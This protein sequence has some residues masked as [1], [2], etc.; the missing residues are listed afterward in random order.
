ME[1]DINNLK[2]LHSLEN[3]LLEIARIYMRQPDKGYLNF[4]KI[5][6]CSG[7]L[8]DKEKG[9]FNNLLAQETRNDGRGGRDNWQISKAR[10][11]MLL[12]HSLSMSSS[13]HWGLA[14]AQCYCPLLWIIILHVLPLAEH[15]DGEGKG[16]TDRGG[17]NRQE[18]V[19]I[20]G[21]PKTI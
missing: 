4:L 17:G 10:D 1:R 18:M 5:L 2:M 19:A 20:R 21:P 14:P 16:T 13:F 12:R 6:M 9:N 15:G 3:A 7:L 11:F 8:A